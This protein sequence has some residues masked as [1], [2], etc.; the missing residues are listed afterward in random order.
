MLSYLLKTTRDGI[1]EHAI[2]GARNRYARITVLVT[3]IVT[4]PFSYSFRLYTFFY[5]KH[6]YKKQEDEIRQKL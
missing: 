1:S 2:N 4:D 3:H 6:V 5:E